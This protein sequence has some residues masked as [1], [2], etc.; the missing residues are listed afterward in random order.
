MLRRHKRQ[1]A[2]CEEWAD[3]Y[4]GAWGQYQDE[5]GDL[6][7]KKGP[8]PNPPPNTEVLYVCRTHWL[9][10]FNE[11]E[12]AQGRLELRPMYNDG[13]VTGA[14]SVDRRVLDA[15]LGPQHTLPNE[16]LTEQQKEALEGLK[17]LSGH[18]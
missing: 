10:L 6:R 17:G 3:G 14:K 8:L 16:R 5:N 12:R 4:W 13:M 2:Y 9:A 15:M 18:E 7:P 1:C 11:A